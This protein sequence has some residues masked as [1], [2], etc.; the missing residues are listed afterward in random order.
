M[1]SQ[2]VRNKT[3]QVI[4]VLYATESGQATVLITAR[5]AVVMDDTRLTQDI[6]DKESF[7]VFEIAVTTDPVTAGFDALS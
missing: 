6:L 7:G 5:R 4:P 3:G 2:K 1:A